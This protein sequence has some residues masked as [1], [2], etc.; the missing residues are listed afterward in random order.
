MPNYTTRRKRHINTPHNYFGIV[1]GNLAAPAALGT[2][3]YENLQTFAAGAIGVYVADATGLWTSA[4]NANIVT[5]DKPFF[6]AQYIG[7]EAETNRPIIKRT[8]EMKYSYFSQIQKTPY[9]A[10]TK[11]VSYF[12]YDGTNG[13]LGGAVATL[14]GEY[15]ITIIDVTDVATIEDQERY[16]FNYQAKATDTIETIIDALVAQINDDANP[17]YR[18]EGVGALYTATKVGAGV[19]WGICITTVFDDEAF[20]IT[21]SGEFIYAT[22]DYRDQ[23]VKPI[24]SSGKG[25]QVNW[26]ERD[27]KAQDGYTNQNVANFLQHPYP[28]TFADVALTYTIINF[29]GVNS[30]ASVALPNNNVQYAVNLEL[31]LPTAITGLLDTIFGL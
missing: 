3:T 22:I 21:N 15:G 13:D 8:T 1:T 24:L 18:S 31:A 11:Q 7:L 25:T 26:M 4:T 29:N 30:T 9:R 2:G 12:G 6:I 5:E 28:N 19:D 20:R 27:S 14:N 16:T 17:T 23:G 10:A